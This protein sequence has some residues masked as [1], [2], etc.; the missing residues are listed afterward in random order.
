MRLREL[1]KLLIFLI[2][3]FSSVSILALDD[4]HTIQTASALTEYYES[5]ENTPEQ[6]AEEAA[7]EQRE[8][9]VRKSNNIYLVVLLLII[10]GFVTSLIRKSNKEEIM[11]R[12]QKFGIA[13]II[14]S[15]LAILLSIII[16]ANW[17]YQ[18]YFLRNLMS[19]LRIRFIE[20]GHTYQAYLIDIPTKYVFF[21]F[22]SAAAYGLTTYLGITPAPKRK[23]EK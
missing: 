13:R 9:D 18:F 3:C 14:V 2:F 17:A 16:S 21:V 11:P 12:N 6:K 7:Q 4:T 5:L 19:T 22:V 8:A 23:V 15:A 20:D 1:I 10:A